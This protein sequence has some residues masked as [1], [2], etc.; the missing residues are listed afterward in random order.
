MGQWIRNLSSKARRNSRKGTDQV[1]RVPMPPPSPAARVI[2][3]LDVLPAVQLVEV[4]MTVNIEETA[5]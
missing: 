5:K 1:K 4:T 2:G 3:A